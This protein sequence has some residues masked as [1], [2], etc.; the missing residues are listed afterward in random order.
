MKSPFPGMDPYIEACGLWGDFHFVLIQEIRNALVDAV[1]ERYLVRTG[2]REYVALVGPDE[3]IHRPFYPDVAVTRPSS[4]EPSSG[5]EPA[6]ALLCGGCEEI[7]NTAVAAR[8]IVLRT[9]D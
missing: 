9:S 7:L 2:E 5:Q 1:P 3:K 4:S 8:S 6:T